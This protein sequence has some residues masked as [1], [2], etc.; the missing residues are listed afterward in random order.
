M[1]IYIYT[2][3]ALLHQYPRS[4]S[5]VHLWTHVFH[6]TWSKKQ[7]Y[8]RLCSPQEPH[9]ST[10]TA[11]D[12]CVSILALPFGFGDVLRQAQSSSGI[13]SQRLGPVHLLWKGFCPSRCK[14]R[15]MLVLSPL[16]ND[17]LVAVIFCNLHLDPNRNELT[18][19]VH[20][21]TAAWAFQSFFLQ[22]KNALATVMKPI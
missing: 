4:D 17:V 5:S 12:G 20:P 9:H 6:N 18:H 11:A 22:G 1:G 16:P 21:F 10:A 15:R 13:P 7:P 19:S 3:A 8:G 14:P 2:G